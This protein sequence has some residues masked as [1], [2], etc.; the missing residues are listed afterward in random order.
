MVTNHTTRDSAG[1][2]L[3]KLYGLVFIPA[4]YLANLVRI[5]FMFFFVSKFGL[6]YY[7]FVHATLW[8][9]GLI[10]TILVFW[11]IWIRV[12]KAT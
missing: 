9:W 1:S 10:L 5:W 2:Y 12:F 4:V 6:Y 11:V 7:D 8:S 3:D